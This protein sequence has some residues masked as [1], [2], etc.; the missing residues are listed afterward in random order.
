MR[1]LGG[2]EITLPALLLLT[3]MVTPVKTVQATSL[4]T[5]EFF[6]CDAAGDLLKVNTTTGSGKC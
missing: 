5:G 4:F 6:A 3:L 2:R 1:C